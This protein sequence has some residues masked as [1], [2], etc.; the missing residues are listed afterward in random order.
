M[1]SSPRLPGSR[2]RAAQRKRQRRHVRAERNLLRTLGSDEVRDRP[3]RVREHRVARLRGRKRP[4]AI[5]VAV[6]QIIGDRLGDPARRLA[7]RGPVEEDRGPPRD[8]SLKA[9]EPRANR[10]DRKCRGHC[11]RI[12][13]ES[14][15]LTIPAAIA[16]SRGTTNHSD[17][18][19]TASRE[20]RSRGNC[21]AIA[22]A[23]ASAIARSSSS[24][25][26]IARR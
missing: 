15:T 2:E 12:Y 8:L 24:A 9:G 22:R 25:L 21:R 1:I 11:A 23:A 7:A 10:I 20:R 14:R 16:S 13:R 3:M 4:A 6:Q 17:R 18:R 5:R 19:S 26:S